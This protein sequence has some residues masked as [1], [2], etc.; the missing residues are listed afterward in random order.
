MRGHRYGLPCCKSWI[1]DKELPNGF[2]RHI[3]GEL[4]GMMPDSSSHR[5]FATLGSVAVVLAATGLGIW[6]AS[7]KPERAT[8]VT[9]A[10]VGS[11][12]AGPAGANDVVRDAGGVSPSPGNAAV[13]TGAGTSGAPEPPSGSQMLDEWL[14]VSTNPDE[15]GLAV[16]RGF[17]R[18]PPETHA[19]AARQMVNLVPDANFGG[20]VRILLDP[21]TSAEAKRTVFND[22]MIRPDTL[23]LPALLRLMR[24]PV[25]PHASDA[26]EVLSAI[27]GGDWG[28]DYNKWMEKVDAELRRQKAAGG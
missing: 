26:R 22:V 23:K 8:P 13:A 15:V 9:V 17:P 5:R 2:S 10:D 7:S 3:V 21:K 25:H 11:K 1:V 27:L 12:P 28:T 4:Q 16:M 6:V 20:V 14:S 19:E 24:Q 18:L